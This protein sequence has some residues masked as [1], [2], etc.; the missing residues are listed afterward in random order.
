VIKQLIISSLT[1][2]DKIIWRVVNIGIG[3]TAAKPIVHMLNNWLIG[4]IKKKNEI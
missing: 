1:A 3:L 4:I 2:H